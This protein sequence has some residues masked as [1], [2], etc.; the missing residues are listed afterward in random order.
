MPNKFQDH[1]S[2]NFFKMTSL[3][4]IRWQPLETIFAVLSFQISVHFGIV[5]YQASIRGKF[6]KQM[7]LNLLL[8]NSVQKKKYSIL[9]HCV[10]WYASFVH[11]IV[12]V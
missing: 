10:L 6:W 8:M 1:A 9:G 7:F 3:D 5:I 2:K 4:F 12:F 11:L